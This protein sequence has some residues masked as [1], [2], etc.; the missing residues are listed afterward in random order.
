VEFLCGPHHG[1]R[2]WW[3]TFGASQEGFGVRLL[4]SQYCKVQL[5][6]EGLYGIPPGSS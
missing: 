4:G 5:G 1:A 3:A 2:G 6:K